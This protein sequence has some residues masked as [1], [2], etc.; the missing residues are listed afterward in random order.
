MTTPTS[1]IDRSRKAQ[2]SA[3]FTLIELLAVLFVLS[4]VAFAVG[5][6]LS[7]GSDKLELQQDGQAISALF[8]EARLKAMSSGERTEITINTDA[9]AISAVGDVVTVADASIKAVTA[10]EMDSEEGLPQIVYFP[11]GTASGGRITL[12]QGDFRY[13]VGVDWLTGGVETHFE[14]GAR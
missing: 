7:L 11:D 6:R 3:G 1:T 5:P 12:T 14:T 13:S 10:Q 4:M 2:R 9:Q 8:R